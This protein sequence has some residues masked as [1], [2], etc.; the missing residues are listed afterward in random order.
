MLPLEFDSCDEYG[1]FSVLECINCLL[2]YLLLTL[3]LLHYLQHIKVYTNISLPFW[4][5]SFNHK[6]FP[7]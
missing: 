6:V 5:C 7:F 1:Y 2:C 3:Y 4:L